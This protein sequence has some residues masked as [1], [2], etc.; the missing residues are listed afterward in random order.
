M[1]E[2]P[3][4]TNK[5]DLVIRRDDLTMTARDLAPI[6]ASSERVFDRGVPVRIISTA[7]SEFPRVETMTMDRV[8]IEAHDLARPIEL[9][10]DA[11]P[12]AKTLPDRVARLYLALGEWGLPPLKGITGARLLSAD[13]AIRAAIGC[14][15]VPRHH[16]L[17][18]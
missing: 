13:G 7:D 12:C 6:I 3:P 1:P 11:E 10:C 8:V 15:G 16:A 9:D 18:P 4:K 5:P 17:S 14:A 2:T